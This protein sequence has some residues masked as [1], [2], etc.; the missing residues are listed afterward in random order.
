MA[1]LDRDELAA[2]P[3]DDVTAYLAAHGWRREGT[4]G[5]AE[6]WSVRVS[7]L[8]V[9][10]LVPVNAGFRDYPARLAELV[11]TLTEVEERPQ[12]EVLRDLRDI[13]VDV[14]HVRLLPGTPHGTVPLHE[15]HVAVRGVHNLLLA[16]ATSAL[17]G[18]APAVLPAQRPPEAW[19]FLRGVRLGQPG[20]GSYVLRVETPLVADLAEEPGLRAVSSRDVLTHLHDAVRTAH[21]VAATGTVFDFEGYAAAGVTANLCKA[22]ADLG[23]TQ[24]TP[25]EIAF[26]WAPAVPLDAETPPLHFD[27]QRITRL[28]D[29]GEHLGSVRVAGDATIEGHVVELRRESPDDPGT[30]I[31]DGIVSSADREWH[32]RITVRLPH[33]D[34]ETAIRAHRAA[35]TV[36]VRGL[37]VRSGN[38]LDL[39]EVQ[40]IT[41]K[42]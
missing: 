2:I 10:V 15:G 26:E 5:S 20:S 23:G 34:Y 18:S 30:V 1:G 41:V 31:V 17:L 13:R 22:L 42:Q 6:I 11:R 14:Q 8:D 4:Q 38:R 27:R 16:A 40:L 25:F 9:D 19:R 33:H 39:T 28:K 36:V 35:A 3:L 12:A 24:R 37:L 7:S 32:D 29:A 21:S